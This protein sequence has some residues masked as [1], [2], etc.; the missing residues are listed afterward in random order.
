MTEVLMR[1]FVSFDVFRKWSGPA[2]SSPVV[3]VS[4]SASYLLWW[5]DW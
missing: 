4:T 1:L 5:R 3:M 2:E